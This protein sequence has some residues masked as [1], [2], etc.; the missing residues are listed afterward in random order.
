[1]VKKIIEETKVEKETKKIAELRLIV[2]DLTRDIKE[3]RHERETSRQIGSQE[4]RTRIQHSL[5]PSPSST[6]LSKVR[7][8]FEPMNHDYKKAFR[9]EVIQILKGL[10]D[11]L[12]IDHKERWIDIQ[13]NVFQNTMPVIK[14][15]LGNQFQYTDT[16]LKK[17]LQNL[18]RHRRDAYAISKDPLKSTKNRHEH[19]KKRSSKTSAPGRFNRRKYPEYKNQKKKMVQ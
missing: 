19:K 2:S 17:V 12:L 18:Y 14:K 6:R 16:E 9:N 4:N 7:K 15:A 8:T 11:S 13:R 1:M 3:L 5:S 10:D